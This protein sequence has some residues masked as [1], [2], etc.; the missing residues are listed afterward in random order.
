MWIE[1]GVIQSG[2]VVSACQPLALLHD[3]MD[4]SWRMHDR[5]QGDT[6]TSNCPLGRAA[7]VL[8]IIIQAARPKGV[9]EFS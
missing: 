9:S 5:F 8:L 1:I 3:E 6:S 7:I 4:A 2:A